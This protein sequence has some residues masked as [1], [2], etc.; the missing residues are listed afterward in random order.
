MNLHSLGGNSALL[1]CAQDNGRLEWYG[2]ILAVL[3]LEPAFEQRQMEKRGGESSHRVA[4]QIVRLVYV[5][6]KGV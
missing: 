4:T 6:E 3:G 1:Y 5:A 2:K